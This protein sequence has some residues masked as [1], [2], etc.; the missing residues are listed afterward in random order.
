MKIFRL[1]FLL[2]MVIL[3]A[4]RKETAEPP[5]I[6]IYDPADYSI[7]CVGDTLQVTASV[8]SS[9]PIDYI[10][11]ALLSENYVQMCP[12]VTIYPQTESYNVN[13][14]YIISNTNLESGTYYLKVDAANEYAASSRYV[15]LT[16][17]GIPRESRSLMVFCYEQ[18]D[19][20]VQIYKMDSLLQYSLFKQ[21]PDDFGGGA[22]NSRDQLIYSMGLYEGNLYMLNASDGS[23]YNQINAVI[24]PPFP[25]F[26][27]VSYTNNLLLVGYY[28]GR[29]Q[30]YFGN[31]N[32]K[33]MYSVEN[34]RL[35]HA[36]FDGTY[37]LSVLE[38]YTGGFFFTGAIYEAS[39]LLKD[40]VYGEYE[41]LDLFRV[42]GN[43]VVMFC[44]A[45]T[46]P[47]VRTLDTYTMV[48]THLK[49]LPAGEIKGV[50]QIDSDRYLISHTDGLFVYSFDDNAYS[51]IGSASQ[52]GKIQFDETNNLIY[53]CGGKDIN[54]FAYP[55]GNWIGTVT[56]PDSIRDIEI[57]YNR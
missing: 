44:N 10:K 22:V 23:V 53:M 13:A 5:V 14:E 35:H 32:L 57:L 3:S 25:Y 41:V 47:T 15:R 4:C 42:S 38:Y 39:G 51:E 26:E 55:S 18:A 36:R 8:S 19:D 20:V 37:L 54:A 30:G 17:S 31:G 40:M 24:D 7:V 21:L 52:S 2:M 11:I 33:F 12:S 43:D 45:G 49:N 28:D 9:V 50:A 27:S 48:I 1:V 56:M 29:I 34:C 46:Q 6:Q 16:V